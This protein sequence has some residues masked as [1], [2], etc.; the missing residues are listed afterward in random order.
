MVARG[1]AMNVPPRYEHICLIDETNGEF[2]GNVA[3]T[4][5]ERLNSGG[6]CICLASNQTLQSLRQVVEDAELDVSAR[7]QPGPLMFIPLLDRQTG[8]SPSFRDLPAL[9]RD[10]TRSARS[11]GLRELSILLDMSETDPSAIRPREIEFALEP[12]S[13]DTGAF[14]RVTL[15]Y[16]FD[17]RRNS[18]A[19]VLGAL[20]EL[21]LI[22]VAGDIKPNPYFDPTSWL[23]SNDDLDDQLR[24]K[25]RQLDG[26]PDQ[27]NGETPD[28]ERRA[29]RTFVESA[30]DPFFIVDFDQRFVYINSAAELK[31]NLHREDL[32]GKVLWDVFPSAVGVFGYDQIQRAAREL[33]ATH[34]EVMSTI[35]GHW[36]EVSVLPY[37]NG[38]GISY[39]DISK[40]KAIEETLSVRV[41]QQATVAELGRRALSE[42]DLPDLLQEVVSSV[43]QTLDVDY[44]KV[45]ELLSDET[46]LRFVAGSGWHDELVRDSLID[47][48]EAS[49]ARY[50]LLVNEPVIV[51]DLPNE[52]R[53]SRPPL[54]T[55]HQVISGLSVVIGGKKRAFGVLGAHT[56]R[57]VR[58]TPDDVNFLQAVANIVA[59][60]IE[61][62]RAAQHQRHY[63][64]IVTSSEDAIISETLDGI[65]TSWN[66]AAERMY[67]YRDDEVIG[68]PISILYPPDLKYEADVIL[69]QVAQGLTVEQHESIRI[70]KRGELIDVSISISPIRDAHGRIIGASKIAR[71]ISERKQS[72]LE[73]RANQERLQLA[74][75]AGKMGT[76]DWNIGDNSLSW[77]PNMMRMHGLAPGAFGGRFEDFSSLVHPEDR[78]RVFQTIEGTLEGGGDFHTEYRNL[79]DDGSTQWLEAR[80][81][82]IRGGIGRPDH[83][84]GVCIDVT[85]QVHSRQQIARFAA[86][87]VA[88]RDQL[89]QIIDVIPEGVIITSAGGHIQLS[90]RA[91]RAIWGQ[92]LSNTGIVPSDNDEPWD[93]QEMLVRRSILSNEIVLS[94]QISVR[95][96]LTGETVQLLMNSAQFKDDQNR[97]AG[98]VTTFQDITALKEFER[99][100]DEFLQMISHDLKN[101]LTSIKGNAQILRR[102]ARNG[103]GESL[104]T[105][106][107]IESSTN[108][109]VI[110]ID[111]LLDITR[112]QMGRPLDLVRKPTNVS[113]LVQQIVE[114]H[115][116]TAHHHRLSVVAREEPLIGLMDEMRISR[117]L[118]NLISNAIKYSTEQ[119][120][121]VVETSSRF[122][123]RSWAEISVHDHG[124]GIPADD[125]PRLFERFRRG[126]NVQGQIRGSGLGLA[127]SKQIVEQHGGT[128]TV[129]SIE[130]RGSTFIVRLPLD[131]PD[132][133]TTLA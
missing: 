32:L 80:G 29:F 115:Q 81:R 85:E 88:E 108:Q 107:R 44:V 125:L 52:T 82:I 105:I 109:A 65:I 79:R 4:L 123:G 129:E 13:D 104:P 12:D 133:G 98:A 83:L 2:P 46:A 31:W 77:S 6:R 124:I 61:H 122:D 103:P 35:L 50:T 74:L 127:S 54:L 20:H 56:G 69:D 110:L 37:A 70:S 94:D 14:E 48:R 89:Q 36:V 73:R 116:A 86:A 33:V 75:E 112:L 101:P 102:R 59:T 117:V 57:N 43:R 90:N 10:E 121:I 39:R 87:A 72:D 62:D 27:L 28:L 53:F 131:D 17:R 23:T 58:F 119:S 128:I 66:A 5:V 55:D 63:A 113:Q 49:L 47:A 22:L 78:D 130:G 118:S 91:A 114:Q 67:G 8:E 132:Q 111:E 34:F 21:P 26:I 68:L 93:L 99:Q 11:S 25:L 60:A 18:P 71:D 7:R 16:H 30:T 42:A 126:S 64:A 15:I 3:A 41:R 19:S 76:W 9:L 51:E 97:I 24:Q 96:E 45:L 38:L 92:S 100:K 1:S 120:E 40:R 95:N 106:D 84:T